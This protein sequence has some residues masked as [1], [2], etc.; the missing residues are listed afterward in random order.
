MERQLLSTVAFMNGH[1]R[2]ASTSIWQRADGRAAAVPDRLG[3]A[4]SLGFDLTQSERE[5]L[6]ANAT[7]DSCL[8]RSMLMNLVVTQI[9]ATQD[10]A[11]RNDIIRTPAA[12]VRPA[13]LPPGG[14]ADGATARCGRCCHR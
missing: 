5:F 11:Q 8:A 7:H 6:A 4:S 2:L 12:G 3:L 14:W 9:F 13:G 10:A 1:A